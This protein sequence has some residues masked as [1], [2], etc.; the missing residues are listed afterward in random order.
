MSMNDDI[1]MTPAEERRASKAG[2][3]QVSH[4]IEVTNY[5]ERPFQITFYGTTY[6]EEE[7][8]GPK[9]QVTVQVP[10]CKT[11]RGVIATGGLHVW[12]DAATFEDYAHRHWG[13]AYKG[14]DVLAKNRIG[15]GPGDWGQLSSSYATEIAKNCDC[16]ETGWLTLSLEETRSCTAPGGQ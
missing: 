9:V 10:D 11:I 13:I 7:R 16:G 4:A 2:W 12:L 3:D 6:Y 1:A 8:P 14:G 15:S 5:N